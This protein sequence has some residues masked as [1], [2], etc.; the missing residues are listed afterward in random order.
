MIHYDLGTISGERLSA[1]LPDIWEEMIEELDVYRHQPAAFHLTEAE[2]LVILADAAAARGV[3]R[4][5]ANDFVAAADLEQQ[6]R[7]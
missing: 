5:L 6:Y 3:P 4:E 1:S 2:I 7:L